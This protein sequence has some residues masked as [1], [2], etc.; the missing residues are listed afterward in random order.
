M[1]ITELLD[2]GPSLL[3]V[4]DGSGADTILLGYGDL[5]STTFQLLQNFHLLEK[6][7][8]DSLTFILN[9]WHTEKSSKQHTHTRKMKASTDRISPQQRG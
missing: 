6:S 9:S 7:Q 3:N 2:L 8:H 1:L 4:V 5:S